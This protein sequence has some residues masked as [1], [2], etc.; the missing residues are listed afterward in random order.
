MTLIY[1]T[2]NFIAEAFDTPHISREE[3]GHIRIV[4]KI[5]LVDRQSL[6][7]GKAVE[8]MRLTIIVG[9]AMKYAMKKRGVDIGRINY[10]ENGNWGVF[11][12]EGPYL[13]IHIYGRAK[14]AKK[15]KYG[16]AVYLPKRETGF[17]KGFKPLDEGDIGEIRKKILSLFKKSKYKDSN[18]R[19]K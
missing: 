8:L 18:W 1:E 6:S 5:R 13:H 12:P 17:Y 11:K 15:Q 7:P 19:L 2:K 9:E 14:K 4:P 3:G 10:Q 16:E